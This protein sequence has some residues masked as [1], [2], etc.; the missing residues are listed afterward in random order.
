[1][2]LPN[3]INHLI[4]ATETT[5]EAGVENL[6]GILEKGSEVLTWIIGNVG[7]VGTAIMSNDL[8]LLGTFV[9]VA[10]TVFNFFRSLLHTQA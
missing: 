3:L 6:T 10:G 1:M 2:L 8:L 7:S 5:T 4:T 9:G